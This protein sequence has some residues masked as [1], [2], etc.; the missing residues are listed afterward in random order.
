MTM[1]TQPADREPRRWSAKIGI[2]TMTIYLCGNY[3]PKVG[4]YM[5]V[6]EAKAGSKPFTVKVTE[7][8]MWHYFKASRV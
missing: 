5:V 6:R 2:E 3:T 4:R 1:N 8:T 7:I